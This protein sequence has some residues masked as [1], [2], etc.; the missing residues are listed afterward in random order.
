MLYMDAGFCLETK[1]HGAGY[2][3]V[4]KAK[5]CARESVQTYK[6]WQFSPHLL[7]NNSDLADKKIH[8]TARRLAS[9][10]HFV[11]EWPFCPRK[12]TIFRGQ[13]NLFRGENDYLWSRSSAAGLKSTAF[14]PRLH[15]WYLPQT[16]FY[17]L[18]TYLGAMPLS[19]PALS[20][21]GAISSP[22]LFEET[23]L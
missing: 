7:Q 22:R 23:N 17:D 13:N 19:G 9:T 6:P 2:V 4:F 14:S 1:E 10:E 3:P 20:L 12:L 15:L 18:L 5:R 21:L 11:S 16:G 8:F